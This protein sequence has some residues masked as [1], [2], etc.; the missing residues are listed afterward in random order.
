MNQEVPYLLQPP[1]RLDLPNPAREEDNPPPPIRLQRPDQLHS[2]DIAKPY[3]LR[4]RHP[5]PHH[6]LPR[7]LLHTFR[8]ARNSRVL[9]LT[10]QPRRIPSR[11]DKS[12]PKLLRRDLLLRPSLITREQ[13]HEIAVEVDEIG[14]RL[15][16]LEGICLQQRRSCLARQNMPQFPP[17]IEPILQTNIHPL[18]RLRTMRMKRIA[19]QKHTIRFREL[20][21]Q[22][23]SNTV[24]TPP[25][26][27]GKFHLIRIEDLLR[28]LVQIGQ[29]DTLDVRPGRELD[30]EAAEGAAFAGDYEQRAAVGVDRDFAAHVGEVCHGIDVHYA[31]DGVG[32]VAEHVVGEGFADD[33]VGAVA[34]LSI[35][36]VRQESTKVGE[37]EDLPARTSHGTS[38]PFHHHVQQ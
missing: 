31:P 8:T 23:L 19:R 9:I 29:L 10:R 1:P 4:A 24:T 16:P 22:S 36:F 27:I 35:Q 3:H 26:R 28:L 12:L 21:R 2:L 30:V 38:S 5:H 13:L 33:G 6:N 18:P 20:I 25:E 7:Q 17:D 14:G 15:A 37:A 11:L 34:A 32:G